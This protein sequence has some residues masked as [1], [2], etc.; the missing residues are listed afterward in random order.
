[1]IDI[2]KYYLERALA[3]TKPGL[4]VLKTD[5]FNEAHGLP[6]PGGIAG[7]LLDCE[8]TVVEKDPGVAAAV[9]NCKIGDIRNIR[10][11]FSE[12]YFDVVLDLSTL[13]HIPT[14]DALKAIRQYAHVLKDLSGRLILFAWCSIN[15]DDIQN[16]PFH[17]QYY[18]DPVRIRRT[19]AKFFCT[20]YDEEIYFDKGRPDRFLLHFEGTKLPWD[21]LQDPRM[22]ERFKRIAKMVS[23][24]TGL[25]VLDLNCG[26]ARLRHYIQ[27]YDHYTGVDSNI[28]YLPKSDLRHTFVNGT[29]CGVT[30]WYVGQ[31]DVLVC[32]GVGGNSTSKWES[33]TV[34]DSI[35]KLADRYR[36]LW[37]ALENPT[38]YD[39]GVLS[40]IA[41]RIVP[42]GYPVRHVEDVPAIEGM[43]LS[44]R[45]VYV[46]KRREILR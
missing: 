9:P 36:P 8:T 21:Y 39:N 18:L 13:D 23:D 27:G 32:T 16:S 31:V 26:T 14:A 29:D 40:S 34:K 45:T 17:D 20:N 28:H 33:T 43:A 7:A 30:G 3:N 42:F 10:D 22:D 12:R 46:M 1:M 35:V 41:D 15:A 44:A 24:W 25:E 5:A 11:Y 19:L 2:Q 37:V 6:V 38:D 4:R